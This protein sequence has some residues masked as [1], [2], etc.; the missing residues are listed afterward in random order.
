VVS[1]LATDASVAVLPSKSAVQLVDRAEVHE[2][3]N[4]TPTVAV[5]GANSVTVGGGAGGG[6]AGAVAG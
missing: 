4:G 5:S 6:V 2:M 3:V 1:V